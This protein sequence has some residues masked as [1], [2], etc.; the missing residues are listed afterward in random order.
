M[1]D[2]E[3]NAKVMIGHLITVAA[4]FAVAAIFYFYNA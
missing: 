4:M 1:D 2:P 3:K